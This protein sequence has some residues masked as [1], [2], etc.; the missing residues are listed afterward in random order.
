MPISNNNQAVGA[1]CAR[2]FFFAFSGLGSNV[3]HLIQLEL[4]VIPAKAGIQTRS[5]TGAGVGQHSIAAIVIMDAALL[6]NT[7]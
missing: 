1:S 6:E 5:A 3:G 7:V 4:P 2:G